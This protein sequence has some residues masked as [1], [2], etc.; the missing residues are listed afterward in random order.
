MSRPDFSQPNSVW[1]T[2]VGGTDILF[3]ATS[4]T[5]VVAS[6]VFQLWNFGRYYT[7]AWRF[8]TGQVG[9][10]AAAIFMTLPFGLNAFNPV[11]GSAIAQSSLTAGECIQYSL[12]TTSGGGG[13]AAPRIRLTRLNNSN[14][15]LAETIISFGQLSF[16]AA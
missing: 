7:F 1:K 10:D 12:L 2:P 6:S 14:W 11:F 5:F 3:S 13:P 9:A 16:E 15:L 8:D 4:T